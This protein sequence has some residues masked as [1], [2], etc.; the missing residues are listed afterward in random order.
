MIARRVLASLYGVYRGN[1]GFKPRFKLI[2]LV[3]KT[4]NFHEIARIRSKIIILV[5]SP[6]E[7]NQGQNQAWALNDPD[8][9]S[10]I[11]PT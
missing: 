8:D 6:T 10:K 11:L 5:K 2:T 1:C 3:I 7:P 4:V 9:L